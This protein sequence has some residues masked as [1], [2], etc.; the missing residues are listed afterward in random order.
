[1]TQQSL[2][3]R[4]GTTFIS[5]EATF[6]LGG[7]AVSQIWPKSGSF[8]DAREQDEVPNDD[9][10]PYF[11]DEKTALLGL[12]TGGCK[13]STNVVPAGGQLNAAASPATPPHSV[14]LKAM[15]GGEQANAGTVVVTGTSTTQVTVTGGQG[16][17]LPAGTLCLDR[18]SVV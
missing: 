16:A 18:K 17:R 2:V 8:D 5:P 7:G 12:K 11:F 15:L 1:M 9:E 13:F 14:A 10:S 3:N 4:L 6:G